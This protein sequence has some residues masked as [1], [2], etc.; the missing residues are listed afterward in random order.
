MQ[1]CIPELTAIHNGPYLVRVNKLPH[2][3]PTRQPAETGLR[4]TQSRIGRDVIMTN[5]QNRR[6][7]FL[8]QR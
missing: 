1:P 6:R 2:A 3:N 5:S 8:Q 4:D 7:S